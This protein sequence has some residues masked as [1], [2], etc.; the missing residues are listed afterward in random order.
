MKNL[1]IIAAISLGTLAPCFAQKSPAAEPFL[2]SYD[3]QHATQQKAL[4]HTWNVVDNPYPFQSSYDDLLQAQQKKIIRT[5]NAIEVVRGTTAP[6]VPAETGLKDY[7][8]QNREQVN[9]NAA[10]KT[11]IEF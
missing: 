3:E 6:A 11:A 4:M 10:I 8:D 1:L 2:R 9:M 5:W 7:L